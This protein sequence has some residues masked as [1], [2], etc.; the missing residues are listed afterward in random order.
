MSVA[1]V[2]LEFPGEQRGVNPPWLSA[3][4]VGACRSGVNFPFLSI[5]RPR[6]EVKRKGTLASWRRIR[7]TPLAKTRLRSEHR[8]HGSWAKPVLS[9]KATRI[10]GCPILP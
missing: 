4:I 7:L 3:V 5:G 1:I 9:P 2:T 6:A 10:Y 8:S